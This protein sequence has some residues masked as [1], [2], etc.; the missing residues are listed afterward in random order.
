[1]LLIPYC[2][3]N[4]TINY[5]VSGS[6]GNYFRFD[7]CTFSGNKGIGSPDEIGAAISVVLFSIFEQRVSA[8]RHDIVNW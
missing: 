3:L 7:G 6:R 1:M 8:V 5:N 4:H 2:T